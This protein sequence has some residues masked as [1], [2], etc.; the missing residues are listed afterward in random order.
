VVEDGGD[1]AIA[2][3]ASRLATRARGHAL[4]MSGRSASGY[5]GVYWT[6][7]RGT[8]FVAKVR[9]DYKLQTIGY[10]ATAVDAAIA[11]A[12]HA[13][14][15]GDGGDSGDSDDDGGGG[16]GSG[17][18]GGGQGQG[19]RQAQGPGGGLW[20]SSEGMGEGGAE[21]RPPSA[22]P[23]R[24]GPAAQPGRAAKVARA[25]EEAAGAGE[26]AGVGTAPA[27]VVA[28]AAVGYEGGAMMPVG[29]APGGWDS[30]QSA[31]VRYSGPMA[32][33][34]AL[35][36]HCRLDQYAPRFDEQGYDDLPHIL[37]MGPAALEELGRAVG[38]K[39]GHF[40][41]FRDLIPNF[42]PPW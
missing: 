10:Y 13:G 1:E 2:I 16:G 20:S 12:E 38:M 5:K 22:A 11:Y 42:V 41:R 39:P 8:P 28:A 6:G 37:Q 15:P 19:L 4:H 40:A 33:V 31:D 30:P 14:P 17:G 9:S 35:L 27:D 21:E 3:R 24:K 23:K 29:G 26:A 36:G 25:V 18:D 32:E 7:I 34:D